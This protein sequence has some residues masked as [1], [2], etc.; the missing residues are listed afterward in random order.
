[1]DKGDPE[2]SKDASGSR[3]SATSSKTLLLDKV[4]EEETDLLDELPVPEPDA[5]RA[6][7][8]DDDLSSQGQQ[9]LFKNDPVMYLAKK[10][11]GAEVNYKRL[12]AEEKQLFDNAKQSEVQSF[13]RTQAV[14]RCLSYE[15]QQKANQSGPEVEMCVG[16]E[17]RSRR[18]SGNGQ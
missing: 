6:K 7:R 15:E 13:L 18:R 5:K 3:R 4:K 12:T 8:D 2:P 9:K 1:M 14:R 17:E 10:V 11:N 16:M